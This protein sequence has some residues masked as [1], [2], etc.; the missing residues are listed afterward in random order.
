M[1]S[2]QG[3]LVSVETFGPTEDR[4]APAA[5]AMLQESVRTQ[6]DQRTDSYAA[7]GLYTVRQLQV[8]SLLL[9][10]T[11]RTGKTIDKLHGIWFWFEL[12]RFET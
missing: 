9:G 3:E 2:L 6:F 1:A 11:H 4:S 5:I 10:V 7:Y 8:G 12:V